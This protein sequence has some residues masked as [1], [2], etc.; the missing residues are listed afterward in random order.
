MERHPVTFDE[1]ADWVDER[2]EEGA[3]QRIEAHLESGCAQCAADVAWL[4]HLN[5][6][7]HAEALPD[8]PQAVVARAKRLC[9]PQATAAESIWTWLARSWRSPMRLASAALLL[10][11]L[12]TALSWPI[13]VMSEPVQ[14][15]GEALIFEAPTAE[16]EE[17]PSAPSSIRVDPGTLLRTATEPAGLLLFDG[18]SVE[19]QPGAQITLGSVR[20]NVIGSSYRIAIEQKSGSVH[21][22]VARLEGLGSAFEVRTPGALVSVQGTTFVVTV[23]DDGQ[24]RVVVAEGRVRVRG[25]REDWLLLPRGYVAVSPAG[26]LSETGVLSVDEMSAFGFGAMEDDDT[27]DEPYPGVQADGTNA[28]DGV[29]VPSSTPHRPTEAAPVP[30]ASPRPSRTATIAPRPSVTRPTFE[31]PQLPS[32]TITYEPWPTVT[33]PSTPEEP[34]LPKPILTMTLV[35]PTWPTTPEPPGTLPPLD[36]PTPALPKPADKPDLPLT[37][38]P[39]LPAPPTAWPSI[40]IPMPPPHTPVAPPPV[41]EDLPTAPPEAGISPP[42]PPVGVPT[43]SISLGELAKTVEPVLTRLSTPPPIPMISWPDD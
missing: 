30:P 37:I 4:R 16:S 12:V 41:P 1:L 24:T 10:V 21:Y 7:S 33:W 43:L 18:S 34:M 23:T 14:V 40:E 36:I 29:H 20:K 26:L 35:M 32:M 19:M 13:L 2:L 6:V 15:M 28:A 5:Q 39:E 42:D 27:H 9:M 17:Q 3:R 22:N 11:L 38:M 31:V 8:P 25:D